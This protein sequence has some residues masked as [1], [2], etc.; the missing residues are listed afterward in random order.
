MPDG[1]FVRPCHRCGSEIWLPLALFEAARHSSRIVFYCPFGHALIFVSEGDSEEDR[2][3]REC[4]RLRQQ[5]AMKDGLI[6]G[7]KQ[8]ADKAIEELIEARKAHARTRRRA[9]AGVCQ[10]CGRTVR[11]MALHMKSKH[12]DFRAEAT[13]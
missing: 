3:R 4:D 6:A 11:Q 9:A 2:L 13:A 12:P 10:C 7:H 1:R 5:I 8:I